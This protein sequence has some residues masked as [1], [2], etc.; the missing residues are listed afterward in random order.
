MG[1]KKGS[2]IETKKPI[3]WH[4]QWSEAKV[5]KGKERNLNARKQFSFASV[6]MPAPASYGKNSRYLSDSDPKCLQ[7]YRVIEADCTNDLYAL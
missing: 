1:K 3:E 2:L 4:P 7:G 5:V 6:R